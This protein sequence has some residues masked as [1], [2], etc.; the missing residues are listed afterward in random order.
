MMGH[1]ASVLF[2][3]ATMAANDGR[4]V[5]AIEHSQFTAGQKFEIRTTDRT[6]RGELVDG[7]T[8]AC[9]IA[10][11]VDGAN[12]ETPRTVYLLGATAG[13]TERQTLVLMRQVRVGLKMELGLGGLE[14]GHRVLSA[15]VESI[16]LMR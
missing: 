7:S 8:G 1:S 13:P 4:E 10:S 6:Y 2:A 9:Q 12:F 16:R 3:L 14:P 15:K 11:S 5:T